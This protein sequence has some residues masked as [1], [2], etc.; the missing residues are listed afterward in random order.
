MDMKVNNV[1]K[2]DNLNVSKITE[3]HT[4]IDIIKSS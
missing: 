2:D 3:Y 1:K 4:E